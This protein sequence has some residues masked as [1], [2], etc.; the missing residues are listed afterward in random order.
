MAESTKNQSTDGK[1]EEDDYMGD[2]TQFLP[3]EPFIPTKFSLR[4]VSLLL[5]QFALFH[6]SLCSA[7]T[8]I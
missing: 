2:L 1:E 6:S 8:L 4:K 3:S 7:K 5:L